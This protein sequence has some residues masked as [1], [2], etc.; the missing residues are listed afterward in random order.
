LIAAQGYKVVGHVLHPIG[1]DES[2]ENSAIIDIFEYNETISIAR[3]RTALIRNNLSAPVQCLARYGFLDGSLSFFDY[4]C[5]RGDDVRNLRANGL[6]AA[7]W[8][9]YFAPTEPLIE[10]ELVNLGFVINV[11]ED[12]H[13]RVEAQVHRNE[14]ASRGNDAAR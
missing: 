10:M 9:P 4:G 2:R 1:N 14:T 12:R 3:H 5:G 6:E 11:I 13:E 8:D 7:G